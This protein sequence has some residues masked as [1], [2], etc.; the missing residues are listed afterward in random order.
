MKHYQMWIGGKWVDA[1]SGK[2]FPVFNPATEEIIAELPMGGK[3][4]VEKAVEA[5]RKAFPVWSRKPQAERSQIAMK[6]AE[7]LRANI[8]EFG[9][10]DTL[11]HGTPTQRANFLPSAAPENFEW[12]A[13]NARSLMGH[14]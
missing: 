13:Y 8:N 3:T 4:D 6:I 14:T 5:A 9:K 7:L 2:T 11:D 10:L 1:D 12:A